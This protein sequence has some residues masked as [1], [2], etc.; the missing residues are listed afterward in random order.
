MRVINAQEELAAGWQMITEQLVVLRDD[1]WMK[2]HRRQHAQALF[3]DSIEE[4]HL[5]PFALRRFVAR[6]ASVGLILLISHWSH[7]C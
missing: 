4:R 6:D 7:V 3:D 2:R 1:A 5:N